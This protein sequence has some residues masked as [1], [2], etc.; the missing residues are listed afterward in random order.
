M[1]ASSDSSGKSR[2]SIRR[3]AADSSIAASLRVTPGTASGRS[4][5]SP[6]P[7]GANDS[8]DTSICA[9]PTRQ[10]G[11]VSRRDVEA[12]PMHDLVAHRLGLR[13]PPSAPAVRGTSRSP[14]GARPRRRATPGGRC[15]RARRSAAPAIPAASSRPAR[16]G[17]ARSTPPVQDQGGRSHRR[18]DRRY[19][20]L[21]HRL[22]QPRRHLRRR[23]LALKAHEPLGRSHEARRRLPG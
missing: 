9:S 4:A 5:T 22:E 20:D 23:A 15:L 19:V 17:M 11:C 2:S 6:L 3:A 10:R 7:A 12:I 1:L 21:V 18:Q 13:P 8:R 14:V 16:S